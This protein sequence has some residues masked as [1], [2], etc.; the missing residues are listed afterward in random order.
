MEV[1]ELEISSL[2]R[3]WLLGLILTYYW[4]Q[5]HVELFFTAEIVL[6]LVVV[7]LDLKYDLVKLVKWG[8]DLRVLVFNA[9]AIVVVDSIWCHL[10]SFLLRRLV[11]NNRLCSINATLLRADLENRTTAEWELRGTILKLFLP[12]APW[13]VTTILSAY[14]WLTELWYQTIYALLWGHSMFGLLLWYF[15]KELEISQ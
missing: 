8:V 5:K 2:G 4:S 3:S 7:G 6:N 10:A 9:G 12:S 13:A 15:P 14:G 1:N 11:E